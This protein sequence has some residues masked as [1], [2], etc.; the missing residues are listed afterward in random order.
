M[1]IK[2]KALNS[3][4]NQ[5]TTDNYVYKDLSL[6]LSRTKISTP[7]LQLPTPGTDIKASFD[8]EAISNSLTNLFNTSPGQRFLFPGYGLNLKR[9]L[10]S[11]INANNG[12]IIGTAI[13]NGIKKYETRVKPQFVDVIASP[14]ENLYEITIVIE[15]PILKQTT[16]LN[17][18]FD[19]KRQSFISLPVKN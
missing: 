18:I 2:I 6:D 13:F 8:L 15:L 11:P 14:D 10:F 1:A 4:T 17:F 12:K 3:L 16:Q 9:F 7:G 5:Y 19:F